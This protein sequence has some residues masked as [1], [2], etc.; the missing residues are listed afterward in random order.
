MEEAKRTV[1]EEKS[2]SRIITAALEEATQS[3]G[4]NDSLQDHDWEDS[5]DHQHCVR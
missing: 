2:S 1:P 3:R 5:P 4:P